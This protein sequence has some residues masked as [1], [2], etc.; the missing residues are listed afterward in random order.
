MND[1]ITEES[2]LKNEGIT[3]ETIKDEV[4]T[5]ENT[6]EDVITK[7][8]LRDEVVTI[9]NAKEDVITK[10]T[11]KDEV[12]TIETIKED[13][14]SYEYSEDESL[15]E[16][17]SS[18]YSDDYEK[19]YFG[20][21]ETKESESEQQAAWED[22]EDNE[23]KLRNEYP[24]A[25]W[26]DGTQPLKQ[27]E[28]KKK[29]LIFQYERHV[30]SAGFPIKLIKSYKEF[31]AVVDVCNNVYL[32]KNYE[33]HLNFIIEKYSICDFVFLD[34]KIL[35][36]S[37]K[38]WSMKEVSFTG[39][40]K[41][42]NIKFTHDIKKILTDGE[43]I[44]VLGKKLVQFN[45]NY[46][47]LAEFISKAIDF[48]ILNEYIYLLDATG[49]IFILNK[50][51]KVVKRISETDA[52]SNISIFNARDSIVISTDS[53]I[54]IYNNEMT[55]LK[56]IPNIKSELTGCVEFKNFIITG[57]KY[58][59]SIKIITNQNLCYNGFPFNR[60]KILSINCM[61]TDNKNIII[62][63]KRSLNILHMEY[64]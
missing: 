59:N 17:L 25:V 39:E 8:T 62:C 1:K 14:D 19:N 38:H 16:S 52:F 36:V 13:K 32:L 40:V 28:K 42:I 31:I 27:L 21:T 47:V 11:I 6:K 33:Q 9:E 29:N 37:N 53:T 60:F 26:V 30:F 45:K 5:I 18:E 48:T 49:K 12:I 50:E 56:K 58:L 44:Y 15:T 41:H 22:S 43:N 35:F 64:K 55:L 20:E 10:E 61:T 34:S 3:I 2:I 63:T 46:S 24:N 57:S 54:K 4:V 23:A 7:E 51:L